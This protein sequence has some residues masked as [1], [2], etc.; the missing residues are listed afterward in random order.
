MAQGSSKK[1]R[2][3]PHSGR[4]RGSE[5]KTGNRGAKRTK[6]SKIQKVLMNKGIAQSMTHQRDKATREYRAKVKAARN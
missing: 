3:N 6:L 5:I 4:A 2:R 1:A